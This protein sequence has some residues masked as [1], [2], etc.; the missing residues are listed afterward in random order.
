MAEIIATAAVPIQLRKDIMSQQEDIA[1]LPTTVNF[2]RD[3]KFNAYWKQWTRDDVFVVLRYTKA[4]K[5][6]LRDP[7]GHEV[8]V[9]KSN[10][11]VL[12]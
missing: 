6:L 12:L 1:G 11:N 4:G 7:A 5:V 3:L 9:A 8:S 10:V 2:S